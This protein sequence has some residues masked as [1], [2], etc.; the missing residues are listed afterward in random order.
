MDKEDRE[1]QLIK[2]EQQL[3]NKV[4]SEM[5]DA[6]LSLNKKLT[7]SL[8][9]AK[10]AKEKCLPD[11]YG[12]LVQAVDDRKSIA[13]S[14]QG[15]E[16]AKDS[17][18][19]HRIHA[20]V[21]DDIVEEIDL[22][23]GLHSYMRKDKVFIYSWQRP[24]CRHYLLNKK[25]NVFID[26]KNNTKYTRLLQRIVECKFDK[27]TKAR[28]TFPIIDE[29]E[30]EDD[31]LQDLAKRRT[32][33][34]FRN[35]VFTIQ[36]RQSEII[37]L[38][39]KQNFIIQGCAGSGKSMIMLHR[40][41]LLLYDHP[42]ELA[43]NSIFIVAPSS[44][45]V[46]QIQKLIIEL[47]IEDLKIGTINQYYH[48]VLKKYALDYD[49]G[50]KIALSRKEEKFLYSSFITDE[51]QEG[52]SWYVNSIDMYYLD[53]WPY[54]M[55]YNIQTKNQHK[56]TLGYYLQRRILRCQEIINIHNK[57]ARTSIN[58]IHEII[59]ALQNLCI[60]LDNNKITILNL[61]RRTKITKEKEYQ[62]FLKNKGEDTKN[63]ARR[64]KMEN[65][66]NEI[67]KTIKEVEKEYRYFE[68]CKTLSSE[69]KENILSKE[70][71]ISL[72]KDG[73]ILSTDST[74]LYPLINDIPY[75][76]KEIKKLRKEKE[77]LLNKNAN[78][79]ITLS[80][81]FN[82]VEQKAQILEQKNISNIMSEEE[83]NNLIKHI[84]WLANLQKELPI[85][86]CLKLLE[87][88][89]IPKGIKLTK[90]P[91]NLAYLLLQAMYQFQ[92]TP[93]ATPD[94]LIAIDE[95][96]SLS[97][98]EYKLI[99]QVND[100]EIIFNLYGDINQHIENTKGLDDWKQLLYVI[101]PQSPYFLYTIEENYRN[102]E[103]ITE[104]CNQEFGLQMRPISLSGGG[105]YEY[106]EVHVYDDTFNLKKLL[107]QEAHGRNAIIVGDNETLKN[108]L[109]LLMKYST[110]NINNMINEAA[111]IS[112]D[113]WNLMTVDQAKGLEFNTVIVIDV[114][115]SRNEKYVA[116]TRALNKLYILK[117]DI[118]IINE[119]LN[120]IH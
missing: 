103:E 22:K 82:E 94:S 89:N 62:K 18:Y 16:L 93:N 66:I 31:F 28:Q 24:V 5:D 56:G 26:E 75:L 71:Y 92:G 23:I 88:Y 86:E 11:T 37:Q 70:I 104:F 43:R 21:E 33:S 58:S 12:I 90:I 40:L 46:G 112:M 87:K 83:I 113:M 65:D 81:R 52:Y 36:E 44:A 38:P 19:S 91:E 61:L 7:K 49:F 111:N 25:D 95:A 59:V 116:Y 47:E 102:A 53:L 64:K 29:E 1:K 69:I 101:D 55:F 85:K 32:D 96:Q 77:I 115:M 20:K 74:K 72:E 60:A 48:H 107:K 15:V 68:Q 109:I 97:L 98:E 9:A 108:L 73:V 34:E 114:D 120:Y 3:L 10:K 80:N 42:Q 76:L 2:E 41:P 99:R 8:L 35:I 30:I 100:N 57:R 27:V 14:I 67:N 84:D 105:V 110:N 78:F 45:Y 117:T 39:F 63:T 79:S 118:F 106:N 54:E 6:I 17:L 4:L 13:E 50:E 119:L 51:I